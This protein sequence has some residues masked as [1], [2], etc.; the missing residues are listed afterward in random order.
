LPDYLRVQDIVD[1]LGVN[2]ETV[3]TWI[4][5]KKLPAIRIGRDYFIDPADFKKFLDERR[6]IK[7]KDEDAGSDG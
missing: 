5:Q 6:T 4:R 7:R 1:V 3:R 2:E